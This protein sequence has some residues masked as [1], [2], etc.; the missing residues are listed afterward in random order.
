MSVVGGRIAASL[1]QTGHAPQWRDA[2]LDPAG[3]LNAKSFHEG[4]QIRDGIEMRSNYA[5]LTSDDLQ[6]LK[7]LG[8]S[9]GEGMS[10]I[11]I[12]DQLHAIT[13]YLADTIV[14]GAPDRDQARKVLDELRDAIDLEMTAMRSSG[15]RSSDA[16]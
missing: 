8:Q 1:R 5:D 12:P 15:E 3:S 13:I 11:S 16:A 14:A 6:T 9:I 4:A 2:E 7:R 10:G